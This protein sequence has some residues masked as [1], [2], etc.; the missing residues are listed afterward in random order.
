LSETRRIDANASSEAAAK[1]DW[2]LV[3]LFALPVG[4][5]LA[6]LP[7]LPTSA[8]TARFFSL[9]HVSAPFHGT[10]ENVLLVPLGAVVVVLFRLTLGIKVLGFFR[11]ILMAMAFD[12]IGI[13]ISL[14]FVLVVLVV[15]VALRRLLT[16][17]HNYSRVGVLLSLAAAC[18]FV[19]LM[20]GTWLNISWL[21]EI[22]LFPVIALCLTCE[23]FA[24]ALNNEGIREAIWRTLTTMLAAALIVGLTGLHGMLDLFLRFPEFLLALAGSIL[25]INKYLDFRLFEGANPLAAFAAKAEALAEETIRVDQPVRTS[26][27]HHIGASD[28]HSCRL[29]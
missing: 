15:I 24:K 3:L 11:P 13:P 6:K 2:L 5:A 23:S 1:T 18:L 12:L 26:E 8:V 14:A 21:R 10:A 9:A 7:I 29:E 17:D 27:G 20:I 22:S 19:P 28:A 25:V 16:T 4:I